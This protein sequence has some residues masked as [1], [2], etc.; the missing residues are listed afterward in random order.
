MCTQVR[1]GVRSSRLW[2]WAAS[3]KAGQ[4]GAGGRGGG[5]VTLSAVPVSGIASLQFRAL[6]LKL[7]CS[8][9]SPTACRPVCHQ[10]IHATAVLLDG[11]RVRP[12]GTGQAQAG[13]CSSTGRCW[14]GSAHNTQRPHQQQGEMAAVAARLRPHLN[15]WQRQAKLQV[16]KSAVSAV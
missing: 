11:C 13:P 9:M 14:P 4:Q 16:G 8:T 15:Q 12:Q 5:A 3:T 1:V 6:L 10:S 7:H 2:Q